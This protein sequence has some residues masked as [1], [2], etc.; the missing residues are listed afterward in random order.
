MSGVPSRFAVRPHDPGSTFDV[1]V[2]RG[3]PGTIVQFAQKPPAEPR[4]GDVY[5]VILKGPA[6][7]TLFE[8]STPVTYDPPST[9]PCEPR[10][11]SAHLVFD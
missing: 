9:N 4:D 10:H 2:L 3:N 11:Y 8:V 1:W 6:D 5:S 7:K